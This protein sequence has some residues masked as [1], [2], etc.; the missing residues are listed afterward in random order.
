MGERKAVT[1]H[2]AGS[3]RAGDRARNWRILDALVELTGWR[4]DHARAVLRHALDLPR[5]RPVRQGRAPVYGADL[6]YGS[7]FVGQCCG[8]RPGSCWH[9]FC[10]ISCRCSG[11]RR[12]WT[13]PTGTQRPGRRCRRTGGSSRP[14]RGCGATRIG[15]RSSETDGTAPDLVI[16][17]NATGRQLQ[18]RRGFVRHGDGFLD[19]HGEQGDG[20]LLP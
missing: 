18:S 11:P 5:P 7:C 6:Q 1:K 17:P 12:P 19:M 14:G 3:Y 13:S 2:L 9:R 8:P 15:P 10:R 20:R 16:S 4:R